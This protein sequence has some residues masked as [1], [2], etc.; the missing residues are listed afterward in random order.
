MNPSR[1]LGLL[2]GASVAAAFFAACGDGGNP[3]VF[4]A[5]LDGGDPTDGLPIDEWALL[6]TVPFNGPY[7]DLPSSPILDAPDGG[8]GAPASAPVLFGSPDSGGASGG[9]CLVEPEVGSLYPSNWLRPRFHWL[10]PGG[11]NLFEVRLHV[12]NQVND[13]VVYTAQ[14]S[15]RMPLSMWT[16]L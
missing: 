16:G 8:T 7:D 14:T 15:W 2:L 9:P 10:A 13:L 5:G 12:K 1:A 6:D 4:D 3:S 11:E